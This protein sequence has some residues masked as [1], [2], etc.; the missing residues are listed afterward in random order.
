MYSILHETDAATSIDFSVWGRF[1]PGTVKYLATAGSKYLKFYRLN[2]FYADSNG[3]LPCSSKTTPTLECMLS[4]TM[5]API[6]GMAIIR[7]EGI[8]K[9]P[10]YEE[11]KEGGSSL[12]MLKILSI[13]PINPNRP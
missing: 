2:P 4:F 10:I 9:R 11:S 7:L 13:K 8:F 12:K 5:M 1:L 3:T 6:R